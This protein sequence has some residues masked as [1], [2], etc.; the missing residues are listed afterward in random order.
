MVLMGVKEEGRGEGQGEGQEGFLRGYS[1]RI[2]RLIF[3]QDIRI[4]LLI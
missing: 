1:N 3:V 4:M 2:R